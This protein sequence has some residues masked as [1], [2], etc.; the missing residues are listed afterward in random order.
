MQSVKKLLLILLITAMVIV[1]GMSLAPGFLIHSTNYSKADAVIL[2]LGPDFAARLRHAQELVKQGTADYLLIPAYNKSYVLDQGMV[3]QIPTKKDANNSAAK[4]KT[5]APR[6]Y[7]DTHLE[8]I[9]AKKTMKMYGR[10]SAIFVSSPYHMRR[11]QLMVDREFDPSSD[12][13]FSPTPYEPA[14]V[15]AWELKATDWKKVWRE[16]VKILWFMSIPSGQSNPLNILSRS[17]IIG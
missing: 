12:Y 8:L 15:N 6:Y 3:V 5:T 4:N 7:E 10:K 17:D 16:Y 11:I 9:E 1:A 13:Y 14:P 2:L